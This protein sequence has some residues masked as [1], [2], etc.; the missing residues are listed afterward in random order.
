MRFDFRKE[1][2]GIDSPSR[3]SRKRLLVILNVA[4]TS[5]FT[6]SAASARLQERGMPGLRVR[7]LRALSSFSSVRAFVPDIRSC[8]PAPLVGN[9]FSQKFQMSDNLLGSLRRT[10]G[11]RPYDKAEKIRQLFRFEKRSFGR[12]SVTILTPAAAAESGM[13][14]PQA[15]RALRKVSRSSGERLS[16]SS[17][18]PG[19]DENL[20]A[21]IRHP[22]GKKTSSRQKRRSSPRSSRKSDGNLVISV[23]RDFLRQPPSFRNRGFVR[24]RTPG[25]K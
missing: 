8:E 18:H 21:A 25:L 20:L 23:S 7:S 9:Q 5:E 15:A 19:G 24:L 1:S 17:R 11:F 13:E 2:F 22:C 4:T 10:G 6:G 12:N 14:R 16:I 3:P